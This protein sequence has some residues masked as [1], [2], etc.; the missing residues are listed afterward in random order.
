[1]EGFARFFIKPVYVALKEAASLSSE[2]FPIAL[3]ADFPLVCEQHSRNRECI[4]ELC[5]IY[6]ERSRDVADLGSSIHSQPPPRA[7]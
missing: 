4:K 1:M 6:P 5:L 3:R 7:L 2:L